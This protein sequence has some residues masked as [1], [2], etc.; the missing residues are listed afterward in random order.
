MSLLFVFWGFLDCIPLRVRQGADR[1][2]ATTCSAGSGGGRG[3]G[4]EVFGVYGWEWVSLV[5]CRG[6]WDVRCERSCLLTNCRDQ[7]V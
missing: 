4:G 5:L 7:I 6:A 1:T 3:D 2:V